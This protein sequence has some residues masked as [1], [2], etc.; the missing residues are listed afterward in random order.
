[1]KFQ[2]I[3]KEIKSGVY[4]PIYFLS[5]E[6]TYFIDKLIDFIATNALDV[7]QR[8]FNQIILYGKDT[9]P[10]EVLNAAK[11]YPAFAER[12]VVIVKE[13]Q[14]WRKF[15]LLESYLENPLESTVLVFGYMHKKLDKRTKIGKLIQKKTIFF[16]SKKLYDNQVPAWIEKEISGKGYSISHESSRL[17]FEHLGNNLSTI[18]NELEKLSVNV[19]H[20]SKITPAIIEKYIGISKDYN[21]FELN[22]AIAAKNQAKAFSIIKYFGKNPKAGPLVMMLTVMYNFFSKLFVLHHNKGLSDSDAAKVAKV[23]PYFFKEY[24]LGLSNYSLEQT[25]LAIH[26]LKEYDGKS[27]GL[28]NVSLKDGA[29][30]EEL[31]YRLMR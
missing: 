11:Q 9:S 4:H 26:L 31:I 27:K 1:M 30:M 25:E 12:R 29:L 15:D 16:E 14:H 24:K 28:G 19:E 5:G 10:E 8:D 22:R 13:V 6:E 17:L 3:Y 18:S 2:D 23:S 21:V 7:S 20:G